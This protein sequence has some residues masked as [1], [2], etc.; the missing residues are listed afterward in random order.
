MQKRWTNSTVL[1]QWHAIVN[2]NKSGQ[3]KNTWSQFVSAKLMDKKKKK[4]N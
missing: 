2:K 1:F 4:P 3:Q